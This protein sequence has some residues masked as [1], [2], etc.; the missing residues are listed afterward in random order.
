MEVV[1]GEREGGGG[2]IA[3]GGRGV[4]FQED[5][6]AGKEGRR[7]KGGRLLSESRN[8]RKRRVKGVKE[9]ER[10]LF[11]LPPPMHEAKYLMSAMQI[12]GVS[13]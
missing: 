7:A 3:E 2:R 10:S 1:G 5:E 12:N 8:R 4:A 9:G 13:D 6:I 11:L